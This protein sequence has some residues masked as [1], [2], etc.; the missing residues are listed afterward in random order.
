MLNIRKTYKIVRDFLFS[1]L[2][3]E[4]LIFLFFLAVSGTFWLLMTLNE[5]YEKELPVVVR[6]SGVP[7]NVVITTD[8]SDTVYVTVKDKGFMLMSYTTSNKLHPIVLNFGNYANKQTGHGQISTSDIQK[9]VRQQLFAS[10]TITAV[11]ADRL[12]FFFNYGRNK[13]VKI[14]LAGNIIPGENYYLAHVQFSPE[15]VTVYASESKLDSIESV[16]T[17]YLNIVNFDDTVVKTVR[18]KPMTGV[19]I[20][21]DVVRITLYPDILTEESLEVPITAINKPDGLTI[22]TFPQR[23]RVRFTVGASMYRYIKS[24]DFQV[25]VDYKEIAAKPSD[26]CTLY[27]QSKPRGVNNA[28]LEMTQVDYL[29]EQ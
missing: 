24:S 13:D 15:K 4:F 26:K 7:K 27:L 14:R 11:K 5:T 21:P 3:K 25:V 9:F 28:H 19:K 10:S 8:I 17:E 12:D 22:R 16:S 2:N 6:I 29:I 23:V 18:L 1:A 20:V